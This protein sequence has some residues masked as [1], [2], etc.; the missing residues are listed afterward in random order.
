MET[1]EI[2]DR[3]FAGGTLR[4]MAEVEG[5][6]SPETMR[7]RLVAAKREHVTEMAGSLLVAT[8]L[9]EVLWLA[10][11]TTSGA[12]L[13]PWLRYLGWLIAELE[14]LS[15]RIQVSVQEKQDGVVFGLTDSSRPEK[16]SR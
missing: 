9:G 10:V 3:H 6:A 11:P 12:E 2:L 5:V 16:E 15:F 1:A 14:S 8:K 13:A 4:E 7:Q